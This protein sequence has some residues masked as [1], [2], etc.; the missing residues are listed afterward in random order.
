MAA[1][2][3]LRIQITS[4]AAQTVPAQLMP[5]QSLEAARTLFRGRSTNAAAPRITAAALTSPPIATKVPRPAAARPIASVAAPNAISTG[6]TASATAKP[7][8][9][10]AAKTWPRGTGA[11]SPATSAPSPAPQ[12]NFAGI[13]VL[14]LAVLHSLAAVL[15]VTAPP[16]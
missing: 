13:A 1:S 3:N 9:P 8:T 5:D 2:S 15:Q 11:A 6:S 12:R 14:H 7:V 10:T 4:F 16:C